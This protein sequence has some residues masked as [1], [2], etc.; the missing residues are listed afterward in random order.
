VLLDL[1]LPPPPSVL[2]ASESETRDEREPVER[3][4]ALRVTFGADARRSFKVNLVPP[5]SECTDAGFVRAWV[6]VTVD[7]EDEPAT[8]DGEG[9]D[10]GTRVLPLKPFAWIVSAPS[11]PPE[12]PADMLGARL[13]DRLDDGLWPPSSPVVEGV[14][15]SAE[16]EEEE[17][18]ER[19]SALREPRVWPG[20]LSYELASGGG[21]G[22]EG[23]IP[24]GIATLG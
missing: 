23:F 20:C 13:A 18:E 9:Y 5:V 19:A 12:V 2:P 8:S 16:E 11:L 3:W 22:I 7:A 10:E 24:L 6:G 1:C 21:S 17:E 15:L 4:D 14:F